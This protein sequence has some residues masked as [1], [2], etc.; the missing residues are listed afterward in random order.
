MIGLDAP[1]AFLSAHAAHLQRDVDALVENGLRQRPVRFARKPLESLSDLLKGAPFATILRGK[2][3]DYSAVG[4]T[5]PVSGLPAFTIRVP[6]NAALELF[7]PWL[8]A[9]LVRAG[10]AR[11]IREAKALVASRAPISLR[12]LAEVTRD[13]PVVA[14]PL[15]ATAPARV[16]SLDVQ[17]WNEAAFGLAP[18]DLASLGLVGGAALALHVPADRR[19]LQEAQQLLRGDAPLHEDPAASRPDGWLTR[20]AEASD[21]GMVLFDAALR[22]ESDPATGWKSSILLGRLQG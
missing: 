1:Q 15:H 22:M 19:A 20:A 3:V 14:F 10:H 11:N 8:Y 9:R 21:P 13:Y 4:F 16:L 6:Q 2:T 18:S 12:A 5:V 7:Q 17:V